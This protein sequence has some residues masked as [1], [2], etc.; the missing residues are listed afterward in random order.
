MKLYVGTFVIALVLSTTIFG[1]LFLDKKGFFNQKF[2]YTM[3]TYSAASF[4]V[5]MPI[6]FSGFN[7][8][9]ISEIL[10]EDDGLVTLHFSVDEAYQKW[11]TDNSIMMLQKP[12]I[13]SAHL[14]L[15][16]SFG[17]QPLEENSLITLIITDDINSMVSRLE[18]AVDD[19]ISIVANVESLT[20]QLIADD[21]PLLQTVKN[22]EK[23]TSKLATDDSLITTVTGDKTAAPSI[24]ASLRSV[25]AILENIQDSSDHIDTKIIDPINEVI[26]Q[27]DTILLDIEDKLKRLDSSVDDASDLTKQLDPLQEQI[28]Y[29]LAKSN[30]ILDRIDAILSS[31]SDELLE[32]P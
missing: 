22:V 30:Q 32:L 2:N 7:I 4:H 15:H 17:D 3:Q 10:L 13:G 1:Y 26:L 23:F 19:M 20:N 25:E 9:A 24:V 28:D 21:S 18:P 16:S 29:A 14:E 27:V 31:S 8:G 12:L 6:N 5:G 11:I